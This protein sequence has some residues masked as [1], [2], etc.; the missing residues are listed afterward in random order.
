MVRGATEHNL[1]ERRRHASRSGVL[2]A[3]TGVSGAGKSSLVN[4]IL[5]P[6][7]AR[8]LYTSTE[9]VGA[10]QAIEGL[11][12]IDKVIAI[13]QKPIGRTPR[14]E[15][16]HVHQGVRPDPRGLRAAPEAR[17]AGLRPGALQL[18]REG[19]ALRGVQRRR[20][21]EGR[22]ALP[23]RRLR[24]LRGLRGQALQR[25]DA[26]GALQ[27]QEHRRRARLQRRR[28]PR[29]V[30]E[31][32]RRCGAILETLVDVGLGYMKIGQ[33]APTMSGGEAQRVKLSRELGK[34]AD[35]AHALRARRADDG[36]ALRGHRASSSSCCSGSSTAGNT[37]VVIEHNLDVIKCA[38]WVIDLGPRAA[39]A[40]GQVVAEGT[41]EQVAAV[42]AS[43]TGQ[44]LAPLLTR[45]K[46][47]RR[48][49]E[50][51]VGVALAD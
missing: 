48:R 42:K 31:H 38:D 34:V 6:A 28:L 43:F 11:G 32:P 41:P 39:S 49:G 51:P 4:G 29:A 27:G 40:G 33:P 14:I 22:D 50:R 15:P 2:T 46:R 17:A 8:A 44:F 37:V 12:A 26:G 18:Q 7:L 19:R 16:G 23:R 3:V 20:R 21:G 9:R 10:H 5:L 35:R 36:P 30:L 13:D 45:A 24:A 1:Q 47:P 25:A